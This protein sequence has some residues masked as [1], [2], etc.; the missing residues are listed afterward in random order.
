MMRAFQNQIWEPIMRARMFT[1]TVLALLAGLATAAPPPGGAPG[2]GAVVRPP[3]APPGGRPP[4]PVAPGYGYGYRPSVSV[5]YG[6]P[7]WWGGWG[8]P[9]AYS[10]WPY[11]GY[12]GYYGSNYWP[13]YGGSYGYLPPTVVYGPPAVVTSTTGITYIERE[14]GTVSTQQ[15]QPQS[16]PANVPPPPDAEPPASAPR[17]APPTG[18]TWWYFCSSPRGAYPYVRECP[19][20]WERVPAVPPGPTR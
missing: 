3:V 8:W 20:G 6:S 2:G 7:Y 19:G 5:Y 12:Y 1:L 14:P 13:Y 15:Q 9:G 17:G 18:G 4:P 16:T 10:Y 11:Y